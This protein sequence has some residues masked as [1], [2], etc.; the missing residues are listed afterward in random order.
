MPSTAHAHLFIHPCLAHA[1]PGH[2]RPGRALTTPV[3]PVA[4]IISSP[5]SC[6]CFLLPHL[7]LSLLFIFFLFNPFPFPFLHRNSESADSRQASS[8]TRHRSSTSGFRFFAK[9]FLHPAIASFLSP[10]LPRSRFSLAFD[11]DVSPRR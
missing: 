1:M 9:A 4:F 10:S 7:T 2:A 6:F 11:D 5:R 8:R 3:P